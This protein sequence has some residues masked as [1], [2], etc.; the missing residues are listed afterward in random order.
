M[1]KTIYI[2]L[3]SVSVNFLAGVIEHWQDQGR[4]ILSWLTLLEVLLSP[5]WSKE[6][7][8]AADIAAVRKQEKKKGGYKKMLQSGT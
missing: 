3:L 8:K 2:S 7:S 1:K 4:I 5:P 6:S